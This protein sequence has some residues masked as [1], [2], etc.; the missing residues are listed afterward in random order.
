MLSTTLPPIILREKLEKIQLLVGTPM[1]AMKC[2]GPC[3]MSILSLFQLCHQIGVRIAISSICNESLLQRSRNYITDEFL[4]SGF[5]HL[6]FIDSDIQFHPEHVIDLLVLDKDFVGAH[7]SY[8]TIDWERLARSGLPAEKLP[9]LAGNLFYPDG[10]DGKSLVETNLLPTGFMLLK[11]RVLE[12]IQ[13]SFP[14]HFYKPDHNFM[15]SFNGNRY[16][17]MF[18]NSEID[19]EELV[20]EYEFLCRNWRKIGGKIYTCPWITVTHIGLHKY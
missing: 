9:V 16:I 14:E 11:R 3:L 18:F 2:N 7:Y 19:G 8:K 15:T 6:L 20:S 10:I 13:V 4:R 1:Y 12:K 5:T 17:Q